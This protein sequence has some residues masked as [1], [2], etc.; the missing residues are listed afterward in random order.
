QGSKARARGAVAGCRAMPPDMPS[1]ASSG[2]SGAC[3]APSSPITF[4]TN[5][6][7][8]SRASA[9]GKYTL[10]VTQAVSASAA[11]NG[12]P[13]KRML[14]S[15]DGS[16]EHRRNIAGPYRGH[17]FD[18][19]LPVHAPVV[20]NDVQPRQAGTLDDNKPAAARLKPGHRADTVQQPAGDAD[21]A[22]AEVVEQ[23]QQPA[24]QAGGERGVADAGDVLHRTL[25][26][27]LAHAA[28][29]LGVQPGIEGHRLPVDQPQ[30]VDATVQ[31]AADA[32]E[33]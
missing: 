5:S 20:S 14:S 18:Q 21:P 24:L 2:A 32:A 27:A 10:M 22:V 9:A 26:D 23:G 28:A 19:G 13:V 16:I 31:A 1:P 15:S 11:T 12:R 4:S 29:R 17:A 6:R 33:F 30:A 3:L 7:A 8:A 25:A